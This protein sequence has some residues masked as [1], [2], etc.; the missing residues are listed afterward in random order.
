[1]DNKVIKYK[2]KKLT[3]WQVKRACFLVIFIPAVITGTIY[4]IKYLIENYA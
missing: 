2:S 4:L 3:D 1:M